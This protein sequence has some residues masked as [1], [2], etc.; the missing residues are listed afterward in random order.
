M[1]Q[2]GPGQDGPAVVENAQKLLVGI[3]I[4]HLAG[5]VSPQPA[6]TG[7]VEDPAF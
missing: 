6:N 4:D 1:N 3:D 7:P 2:R 5:G